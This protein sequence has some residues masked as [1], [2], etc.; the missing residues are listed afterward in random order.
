MRRIFIAGN[1][2]MHLEGRQAAELARQVA[3]QAEDCPGIDVAVAPVFTAIVPVVE[4]L[5][6][7]PVMVAGQNC[8]WEEKGAF[9]GEVA[10][11]M[12]AAAGC[13]LVI[14]GHSER[15]QYFGE[16]D[17]TV[18]RKLQA[19]LRA[20][21][22]PI[23]C[24]GE[25]LEQRDAGQTLDVVGRQ[26][27]AVLAVFPSEQA[28]RLTI[29]YEP[30]W[31]IGTGRT[32]TA[33][34]AQEVHTFIRQRLADKF[35]PDPAGRVRIQYGGSVKPGNAAELLSQPDIDGALVGGASLQADS[36]GAIM[37]AAES[38]GA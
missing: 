4:A 18:G 19:A 29:A 5:A 28:S 22:L 23:V 36:F 21:L 25:S 12:L 8:H 13:R 33:G 26:L 11:E 6:G 17:E 15:R 14:I 31:A 32:A 10:A 16:T 37:R 20:G 1:W 24:L 30:V 3:R 35:G 34:Q 27:E 2:K 9:T 38:Q 7:S